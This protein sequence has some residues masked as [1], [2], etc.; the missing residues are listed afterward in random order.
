MS[1]ATFDWN[2]ESISKLI[3]LRL[4]PEIDLILSK[5]PVQS[6]EWKDTWIGIATLIGFPLD[7]IQK[8]REKYSYLRTLNYHRFKVYSQNGKIL[9]RWNH[10]DRFKQYF[11]MQIYNKQIAEHKGKGKSVPLEEERNSLAV[12]QSLHNERGEL[13]SVPVIESA[14]NGNLSTDSGV[15]GMP[16]LNQKELADSLSSI[17]PVRNENSA[18]NQISP[19][20]KSFTSQCLKGPC[21]EIY[22]ED[23]VQL[24]PLANIAAS[25][26][27]QH[28]IKNK[29]TMS[30]KMERIIRKM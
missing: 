17:K 24:D 6:K 14:Q 2:E 19:S 1:D 12:V 10:F 23:S 15:A 26:E 25:H 28:P 18:A 27:S 29:S 4:D 20:T 21:P 5:C 16:L 7:Q 8:L 3:V 13:L 11:E 30:G 22:D 9:S